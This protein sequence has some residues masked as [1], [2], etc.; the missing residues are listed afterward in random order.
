MKVSS[1]TAPAPAPSGKSSLV[2]GRIE[3]IINPPIA[4][5][6]HLS[7]T[8]TVNAQ[9]WLGQFPWRQTAGWSLLAALLAA[10]LFWQ[11]MDVAWRDLVLLWL[12]VDPIW[13]GIWR[14]A[15]G[16]TELLPLH[17]QAWSNEFWLPYLRRGSPA[18]QLLGDDGPASLPLLFRVALPTVLIA[19][20]IASALGVTALWM[21][22][23]VVLFGVVGWIITRQLNRPPALLQS[24]VMVGMPWLLTLN[25]LGVPVG[26]GAGGQT[27]ALQLALVLLWIIQTWGGMRTI[28]YVDDW[29][30]IGL[31]AIAQIGIG[32][33]L[34]VAQAPLWLAV[35]VILWLPTWLAVYQRQSLRRQRIW[36]LL[37]ML[38]S[39]LAIGQAI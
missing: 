29:L 20:L 1:S 32:V 24:I 8:A 28:C 7:D 35:L 27:G 14:L 16:R 31:M 30:G 33:L 37:A 19:V 21:T 23:L 12:L 9:F 4:D 10:G 34:V 38:V 5:E 15:A 13:G 18:A 22:G 26:A 25:L 6:L 36:W 11:P 17:G 2:M 39:A 3:R